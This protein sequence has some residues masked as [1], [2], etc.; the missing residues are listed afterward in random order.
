MSR[1]SRTNTNSK[2]TRRRREKEEEE[3]EEKDS[4]VRSTTPWEEELLA[5]RKVS[6]FLSLSLRSSSLLSS[7][8]NFGA[9]SN[10]VMLILWLSSSSLVG[11]FGCA[12]DYLDKAVDFVQQ[13]VMGE[14]DQSK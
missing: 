13:H 3:E 1:P 11:L 14:G 10:I 5:K 6:P 12:E 7:L 8:V 4:W 2:E 9:S